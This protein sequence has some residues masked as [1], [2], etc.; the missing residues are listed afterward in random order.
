MSYQDSI[1]TQVRPHVLCTSCISYWRRASCLAL[2]I[3]ELRR[4]GDDVPSLPQHLLHSHDRSEIVSNAS[5]GCHFCS[6]IVGSVVGCTG[7]HEDRTPF[8]TGGPIYISTDILSWE[9]G[10]FLLTLFPCEQARIDSHDLILNT[11]PLR[12]VPSICK[13]QPLPLLCNE[14]YAPQP[15]PGAENSMMLNRCRRCRNND[16]RRASTLVASNPHILR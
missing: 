11:Y 16:G 7:N 9:D 12:L 8:V 4:G 2:S 15:R 5:S 6:I 1:N 10:T 3:E 13:N 14:R